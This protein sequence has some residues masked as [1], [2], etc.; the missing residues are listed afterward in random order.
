MGMFFILINTISMLRIFFEVGALITMVIEVFKDL[1][2]FVIVFFLTLII[3][4]IPITYVNN[5]PSMGT[6]FND[7]SCKAEYD[8][9][10][11]NVLMYTYFLSVGGGS[12]DEVMYGLTLYIVLLF[13]LIVVMLN[14]LIAVVGDTFNKVQDNKIPS[15]YIQ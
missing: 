10:F 9:S 8:Q 2:Y 13:V 1:V 4:A 7:D 12:N 15:A 14:L 3:F 11:V 6:M 5:N